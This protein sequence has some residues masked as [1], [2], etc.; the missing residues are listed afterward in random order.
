VLACVGCS[1]AETVA[2]SRLSELEVVSAFARLARDKAISSNQ[3]DRAAAAFVS[4]LAAWH[5]VELTPEVAA[6]ARRLLV[7]HVLRAGDA[8]QLSA[9]LVLQSGL[10]EPLEEFVAHDAR[11]KRRGPCRAAGGPRLRKR[12][13]PAT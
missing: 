3:R 12:I 6:T 4:D 10:G 13:F 1:G 11:I 8:V 5:I 2:V 9:A 7:Q